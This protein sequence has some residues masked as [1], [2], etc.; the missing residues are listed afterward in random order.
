MHLWLELV[1]ACTWLIVSA[2][3]DDD[4]CSVGCLA[5]CRDVMGRLFGQKRPHLIHNPTSTVSVE[6]LDPNEL[7]KPEP[8]LQKLI[9]F[10]KHKDL[11]DEINKF[12]IDTLP[13]NDNVDDNLKAVMD[14]AVVEE[15]KP[16]NETD[17]GLV[18]AL[19][20]L[21][22]LDSV[23]GTTH[24]LRNTGCGRRDL[25][26]LAKI[27][28]FTKGRAHLP[29]LRSDFNR[30]DYVVHIVMLMHA[31][32]C[33]PIYEAMFAE[34]H[35][36][37]D[38]ETQDKVRIF[39]ETIK[40]QV[41]YVAERRKI[42]LPEIYKDFG[43]IA[44]PSQ[45]LNIIGSNTAGMADAIFLALDALVS[46]YSNSESCL[47]NPDCKSLSWPAADDDR[48]TRRHK[49]G[50][51]MDFYIAS[52]CMEFVEYFGQ[53][54]FEPFEFDNVILEKSLVLDETK[55][56]TERSFLEGYTQFGLCRNFLKEDLDKILEKVL[57]AAVN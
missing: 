44:D 40:K 18:V 21:A 34:L 5:K 53:N 26:K 55:N 3:A 39:V 49:L 17:D 2:S 36:D 27:D 43:Q 42:K 46:R 15:Q 57:Q 4:C 47:E 29:R 32:D 33:E 7:R 24:Y 13:E 25:K 31:L 54:I 19:L 51:L 45:I 56:A 14:W 37:L 48:P 41:P 8:P 30:I 50:R 10:G 9:T 12:L 6:Q 11:Y 22:D 20:D 35:Q 38:G 52:P 23:A 1:L 28:K 16:L